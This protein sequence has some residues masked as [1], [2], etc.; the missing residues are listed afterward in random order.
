MHEGDF[1]EALASSQRGYICS[2]AMHGEDTVADGVVPISRRTLSDHDGS[3]SGCD[4]DESAGHT[5][6]RRCG[7]DRE[8]PNR[9]QQL[10]LDLGDIGGIVDDL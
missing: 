1:T 7:Q 9:P 4:G 3:G 5:L 10:D 2:V 6:E 8:D